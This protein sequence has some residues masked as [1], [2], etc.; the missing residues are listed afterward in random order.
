MPVD[1]HYICKR[2]EN[3]RWLGEVG[4][5]ETGNW[6]A[7]D[8]LAELALGGRVFLHTAQ[9]E[10]AWHGGTILQSRSAPAPQQ[11]RKIFTYRTDLDFRVFC[12]ARW[13][14]QIAT[15]WWAED[16][17]ELLTRDVYLK[18]ARLRPSIDGQLPTRPA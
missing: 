8:D 9:K 16:R 2:G 4:L 14:Q 6:T 7:G 18:S 5:F 15:A 3:F 12:P 1:L 13:S 10:Q 11:T 17:S